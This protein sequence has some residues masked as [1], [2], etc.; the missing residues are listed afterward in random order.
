MR[1]PFSPKKRPPAEQVNWRMFFVCFFGALGVFFGKSG[2]DSLAVLFSVAVQRKEVSLGMKAQEIGSIRLALQ[3]LSS[4]DN[5]LDVLTKSER[6]L[7]PSLAH[8]G[9]SIL[10]KIMFSAPK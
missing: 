1:L 7:R 8:H 3:Q 10:Q 5:Y 6:H 9:S 4:H 2:D